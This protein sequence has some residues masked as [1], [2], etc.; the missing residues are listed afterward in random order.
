[1]ISS[2]RQS[3]QHIS[4]HYISKCLW[5][6]LIMNAFSY[7]ILSSPCREVLPIEKNS[8]EQIYMIL[9]APCLL[10]GV[11]RSGIKPQW[12]SIQ[13]FVFGILIWGVRDD[14]GLQSSKIL[15]SL[16]TN[17]CFCHWI[18]L[19]NPHK[20]AKN[21]EDNLPWRVETV[22]PRKAG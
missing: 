10:P 2:P 22:T 7:F 12:C 6:P 19:Q 4:E 17:K 16:T 9:L 8:L 18:L 1:M 11:G 15:T 5:T 3:F 14:M 13:Y 21:V 20:N